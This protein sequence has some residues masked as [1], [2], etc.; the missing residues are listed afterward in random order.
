L[1]SKGKGEHALIESGADWLIIRPSL[2]E[3]ES[4]YGA[5]W[6]RRIA[7]WPI[8]LTPSDAKGKIAPLHV[9]E[10]ARFVFDL[11]CRDAD[12]GIYEIGGDRLFSF[13]SYLT[14]LRQAEP[15]LGIK[16]PGPLVRLSSHVLDILHLTPLSFGHY[17]LMKN[18]N[19]PSE[20]PVRAR[21]AYASHDIS[22]ESCSRTR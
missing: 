8:H 16:V 7:S 4:G 11:A 13:E 19:L 18:D 6:F 21:S 5:R 22:S 12:S 2:L 20:Y 17:E 1:L 14:Y 3:G 15:R 9:E 10:L